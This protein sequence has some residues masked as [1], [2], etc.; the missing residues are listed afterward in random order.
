MKKEEFKARQ[1]GFDF[2]C[3][4]AV[5]FLENFKKECANGWSK[6]FKKAKTKKQ[7]QLP[8]FITLV[9]NINKSKNLRIA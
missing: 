7:F 4:S 9:G 8:L 6:L 1:N 3:A 2:F 5:E